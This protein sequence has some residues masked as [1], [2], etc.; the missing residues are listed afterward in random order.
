[1]SS[2][3]SSYMLQ[4]KANP[5]LLLPNSSSPEEGQICLRGWLV[6]AKLGSANYGASPK[7]NFH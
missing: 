5:P 3:F 6:Y 1:M 2:Y 7:V 4:S